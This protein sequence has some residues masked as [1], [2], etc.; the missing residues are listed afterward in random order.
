[1]TD[2]ILTLEARSL[3]LDNGANSVIRAVQTRPG[4]PVALNITA[5]QTIDSE[6]LFEVSYADGSL[7]SDGIAIRAKGSI[8][9]TPST[10]DDRGV[11]LVKGVVRLKFIRREVQWS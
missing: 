7:H 11:R 1:M 2:G 9:L 6:G 4:I 10:G 3:V 8:K 5:G